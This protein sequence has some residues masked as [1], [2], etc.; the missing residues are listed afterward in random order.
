MADLRKTH[1]FTRFRRRRQKMRHSSQP[2]AHPPAE[3]AENFS[4]VVEDGVLEPGNEHEV[5]YRFVTELVD[6]A[7]RFSNEV[8]TYPYL[9]NTRGSAGA[10]LFRLTNEISYFKGEM[11]KIERELTALDWGPKEL[12]VLEVVVRDWPFWTTSG[13]ASGCKLCEHY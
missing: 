1:S 7:T 11:D 4:Y 3:D 12:A 9:R 6:D 8:S 10:D 13:F 5:Y 2:I